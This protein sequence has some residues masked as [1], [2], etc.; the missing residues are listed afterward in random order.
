MAALPPW[1]YPGRC[2]HRGA[3]KLA[4][5]NTLASLRLGHAHGYRMAE[6]DVKLSADGV[7]FLLHDTTLER[8]TG[9][10]G[11]ADALNWRELSRLDAGSWHS[12]PYAGETIPTLAAVARWCRAN[13][14]ALNIEIKPTPGRERETGAAIAIDAAAL[15]KGSEVPPLLSS[16]SA[17]ALEAALETVP[18]LPRA[19]LTETLPTD[20]RERCRALGCVALDAK[21]SL[22]RADIVREAHAAGLRVAAWTVNDAE[23][24][25]ELTAWGVDT[26][27]TDAVDVIT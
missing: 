3:G 10:A 5:E 23:R 19:W 24:A 13:G 27:I 22:L 6:I 9:G 2:A 4:P 20:W 26:V 8:T 21:Q 25:A 18:A 12:P 7:P 16:F 15:W 14:V 11:R 1:P 17:T